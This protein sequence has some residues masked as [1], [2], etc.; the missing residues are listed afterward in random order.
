MQIDFQNH[1]LKQL[2]NKAL[3]FQTKSLVQKER[4]LHVQVLH[5]LREIDSRN[6]YFEMGFSSLFGYAIRELGYS[7]GAAYRRIK[8][9]KLCK[10]LPETENRLQSGRLSL[11]AAFQLQTFFEKQAKKA[12]EKQKQENSVSLKNAE[13]INEIEGY[14]TRA[15]MKLLSEVDPSLSSQKEQVRF[16]GKGKVEIKIVIDEDCHKKLKELK[17]LLSHKNPS[18]CGRQAEYHGFSRG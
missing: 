8:A 1:S 17:H 14:S 4:N 9:M 12:K 5:H 13:S 15:T 10:D 3:L 7:E 18:L 16:L 6:L 2:S 11:S